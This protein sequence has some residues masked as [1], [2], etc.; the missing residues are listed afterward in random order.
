[1]NSQQGPSL[2]QTGSSLY[3]GAAG[4]VG[5]E[6]QGPE[7]NPEGQQVGSTQKVFA[8]QTWRPGF[9]S[10]NPH[11]RKGRELMTF[12]H[13]SL[14]AQCTDTTHTHSPSSLSVAIKHSDQ[15]QLGEE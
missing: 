1:M 14:C 12:A 3:T 10:Q 11:K 5:A 13:L 7:K 9:N 8:V 2:K 4:K 6:R 15:K